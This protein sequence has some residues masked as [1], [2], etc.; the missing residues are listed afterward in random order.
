[1]IP[2]DG[3][4]VALRSNDY[5]FLG[6]LRGLAAAGTEAIPVVFD[7][8]GAKPWYSE[9]SRH[10]GAAR[11]IANPHTH[12]AQ[13]LA[14]LAEL[15]A[16]LADAYSGRRM[17]IPSSDTNIM[18][19]L[20]HWRELEPYYRVVGDR[21]FDASRI[22]V[23]RKD[24][25]AELLEAGGVPVPVTRRCRL[26]GDVD[27][28][29]AEVPMPCVY[30]PA[31]KDYGQTFY[32]RHGKRKAVACDDRDELARRLRE[33]LD[34]GFELVVQERIPLESALEEIPIFVYADREH[35][36]R[37][38]ST[39]IKEKIQ[40][41]P[42]GTAT[43]MRLGWQSELLP[44]ARRVVEAVRWRGLLMIEL[45]RDPRDRVWKVIEL[46]PRPWLAID[47]FRRCGLDYVK[48]LADDVAGRLP[49]GD[50]VVTP[51]PRV[52]ARDPVHLQ[53][54]AI[55][56]DWAVDHGRPPS[57]ADVGRWVRSI[58]GAKS[59]SLLDPDDPAPGECE[60]RDRARALGLA[61][62]ALLAEIEPIA[63]H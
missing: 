15:G 19:L 13:A 35:R 31:V 34:A 61:D 3:P 62:D 39:A 21:E 27:R 46:N 44:I 55:L 47:F 38:A 6:A 36:V 5:C 9:R 63:D 16:K 12:G 50:D 25:C 32:A 28:A 45:I 29:V 42:F 18:F 8:P 14:E 43:V 40:P 57:A 51:D 58:A 7:W 30:K 22:E 53:L 52:L 26:P 1:M 56:D 23:V 33:E 37:M 54:G 4:I 20:D 60:L 11:V 24:D 2:D 59:F 48:M 17:V 49:D 10:F 41:P